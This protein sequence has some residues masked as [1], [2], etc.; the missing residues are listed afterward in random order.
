[1]LIR[2]ATG[3]TKRNESVKRIVRFE[4]MVQFDNNCRGWVSSGGREIHSRETASFSA[5]S[6]P[7]IFSMPAQ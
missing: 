5:T 2:T 4:L 7:P 6:C 3:S 1:M